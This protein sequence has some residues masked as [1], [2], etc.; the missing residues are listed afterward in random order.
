MI[1]INGRF[2]TEEQTGVQRFAANLARALSAI[3]DDVVVLAPDA[4][5]NADLEGVDV[6]RFGASNPF[7]WEQVSLPLWLG[8]N[9]RPLLI[10]LANRAPLLY[11]NQLSTLHD[12]LPMRFKENFSLRFRLLFRL[13]ARFGV[14]RRSRQVVSVSESA[15][16][17]IEAYYRLADRSVYVVPN[18]GDIGLS[19]GPKGLDAAVSADDPY[20]LAFGRAGAHR[21]AAICIEAIKSL[22]ADSTTRLIYAGRPDPVLVRAADALGRR[23]TFAGRVSDEELDALYRGAACFIAPSLYE[24]FDLPA[25]EAQS[26]GTIVVASDI[27]IHREVLGDGARY[28]DPLAAADLTLA[29][30]RVLVDSPIGEDLQLAAQRNAARFSWDDSAMRLDALVQRLLA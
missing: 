22:P 11:P 30:Q 26:I 17:E 23:C 19:S 3:R 29:L 4:P 16:R 27:P 25:L 12:L 13:I 8:K 21:N 5:G 1:C 18:A 28:F 2:L 9:D 14:I 6:R 24:G 20:V 7:V 10:N 15:G